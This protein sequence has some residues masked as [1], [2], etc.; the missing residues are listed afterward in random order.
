MKVEHKTLP[1]RHK[2]NSTGVYYKNIQ[3]TT[4]DKNGNIKVKKNFDKVFSIQYKD[5]DNKWKVKTIGKYSE[6]IRENYC[7]T[8][9][10]DIIQ[11]T[12]L[13][14]VPRLL[15]KENQ[16][17]IITFDFIA[18]K[19][20]ERHEGKLRDI[21]TSKGR[22]KNHIKP[23]LGDRD[24]LT[25]TQRDIE[26]IQKE[27]QKTHSR[28]T[29]NHI[30]TLIGT[31]FNNAIKYEDMDIA[32]PK[33]KVKNLKLNNARERYL[34]LNEIRELY[35]KISSEKTLTLFVQLALSTGARLSAIM[36]IRKKNVNLEN[37][38]ISL[39][40]L[41]QTNTYNGFITSELKE[42]LSELLPKLK[43]NDCLISEFAA[44]TIQHK[45]KEI[46]DELFNQGLD[47]NDAKN[48]VVTHTLRHTFASQLAIKGTP[49]YTIKQLMN[50]EDLKMT[51]RY[52]H[53]SPDYGKKEVVDL[54]NKN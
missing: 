19:F 53:L 10:S 44:D 3:K 41:K 48:R 18:N 39:Q 17:D 22:Y 1:K 31:I 36:N 47:A 2:T 16:E 12:N 14:E 34:E 37:G 11:L 23:F 30:V 15:E 8:V 49:I 25:I 45:L 52:A 50:H 33:V 35:N 27:K 46:F 4:T 38:T 29:V 32:N 26:N 7:K 54:Y 28:K 43:I 40:N 21:K 20:F 51:L 42:T 24:I 13:G 5:T 9:R 6:G